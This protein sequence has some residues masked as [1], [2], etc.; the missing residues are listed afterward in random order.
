MYGNFTFYEWLYNRNNGNFSF[1]FNTPDN[2]P[3]S[4]RRDIIIAAWDAK[5]KNDDNWLEEN[6]DGPFHND[7]RL[8]ILN[9]LIEQHSI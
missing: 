1:T 3:K 2:N 6:F 9:F 8:H 4:I 7:C 5:Q